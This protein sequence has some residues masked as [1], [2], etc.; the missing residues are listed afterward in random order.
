M[1]IRSAKELLHIQAWLA[2]A[3]EIVERGKDS[4]LDDDLLQEAGDSLMMKLGE[5]AS[6]LATFGLLAPAGVEWALAIANRNFIIHQYDEID[7]QVTWLT[8]SV[9]LA[10]WRESLSERFDDAERAIAAAARERIAE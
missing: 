5:A 6:R 9:D 10:A 4:Y 1:D 2:R 7:R 8:L 3:A